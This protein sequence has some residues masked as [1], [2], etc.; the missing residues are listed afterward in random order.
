[1]WQ[2]EKVSCRVGEISFERIINP[3]KNSGENLWATYAFCR[4][5]LN[6]LDTLHRLIVTNFPVSIEKKCCLNKTVEQQDTMEVENRNPVEY[7]IVIV[8][9]RD[10]WNQFV[11]KE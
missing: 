6:H 3:W 8:P 1:M 5:N 7:E 11:L 10:Y 2:Q 9:F 4:N